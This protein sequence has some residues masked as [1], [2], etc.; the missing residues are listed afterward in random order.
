MSKKFVADTSR[1]DN[2]AVTVVDH[3]PT[4]DLDQLN[5]LNLAKGLEETLN[6]RRPK[7]VFFKWWG[8]KKH[9][10]DVEQQRWVLEQIKNAI[11]ISDNLNVLKARIFLSP[12]T[13]QN[14]ING[15]RAEAQR[16]SELALENHV[17]NIYKLQSERDALDRQA[18]RETAEI[19]LIEQKAMLI[20]YIVNSIKLDDLKPHHKTLLIQAMVNPNGHQFIDLETLE[21]IKNFA[22][23]E[24]EGKAK[25]TIATAKQMKAKSDVAEATAKKTIDEINQLRNKP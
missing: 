10:L 5:L 16:N 20:E 24:A 4:F 19:K 22:V 12:E 9:A 2:T 14:L 15:Q 8:N 18:K 13:V 17:T 3:F 1:T 6:E 21:E 23:M 25:Q 7:S 11:E